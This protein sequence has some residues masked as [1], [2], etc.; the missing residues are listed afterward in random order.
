MKIDKAAIGIEVSWSFGFGDAEAV[1]LPREA[2]RGAV[3]TNGFSGKLIDELSPN[4]ALRKAMILVKGRSQTIVIQELRS[5]NKDTPMSVGIY[6]V[7]PQEG[8]RGDNVVCGA[9]VRVTGS[10]IEALSP[11]GAA[12]IPE[13][14]TVARELARI[15]NSLFTNVVNRDISAI[16]TAIGWD[17]SWI[18]RRRNSGGVYFMPAGPSAE[19]FVSL[20]QDLESLTVNSAR[21]YQFVPQIMEVY[22]KPLTLAMWAHSAKDQYDAQVEELVAQLKKVSADSTRESTLE[23]RADDCDRLIA[24]AETHRLFLQGHV[25]VLA[26]ELRRVQGE[27][28]A[29]LDAVRGEARKALDEAES[30]AAPRAA[31]PAKKAAAAPVVAPVKVA[32]TRMRKPLAPIA[33]LTVDELFDE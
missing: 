29:K 25:E 15:A 30:S 14:E 31:A 22:A 12:W 10:D 17:H 26:V 20:L 33:Q 21:Q 28:R 18:T 8:E 4:T 7:Q 13:C 5:P 2:V 19:R 24:Q 9:R 27:F 11:E 23:K 6:Q 1:S 32:P 3:V 16:L